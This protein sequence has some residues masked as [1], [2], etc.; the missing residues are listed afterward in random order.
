M[1]IRVKNLIFIIFLE[2]LE[3]TYRIFIIEKMY[4]FVV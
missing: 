2:F 3:V 1:R 4:I